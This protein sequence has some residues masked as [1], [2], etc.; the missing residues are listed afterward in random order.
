MMSSLNSHI[1][2]LSV[3]STLST[4]Q[5]P[6]SLSPWALRVSTP[7]M[8]RMAVEAMK[9]D[10]MVELRR[11]CTARM[12]RPSRITPSTQAARAACMPYS[13]LEAGSRRLRLLK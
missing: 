13:A 1:S 9:L 10:V 3:P 5:V 8:S 7:M 4:C 6:V 11:V 2:E 12:S